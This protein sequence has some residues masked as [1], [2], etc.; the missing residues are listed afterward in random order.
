MEETEKTSVCLLVDKEEVGSIG[1]TGQQSKFFENTVA[2][3]M[4]CAGEYNE[5]NVRRSFKR[6]LKCYLVMYLRHM[7]QLCKC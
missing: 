5:L 4:N 2:E 7:I 3:V 1:A 6:T